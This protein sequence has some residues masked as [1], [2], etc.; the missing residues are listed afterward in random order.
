M[1]LIPRHGVI[2][3]HGNRARLRRARV[4]R[5]DL[6]SAQQ[7][8]DISPLLQIHD[9]LRK[10]DK[11]GV[12]VAESKTVAERVEDLANLEQLTLPSH[13][14]DVVLSHWLVME[15]GVDGAVADVLKGFLPRAHP[16]DVQVGVK[17]VVGLF[18]VQTLHFDEVLMRQPA[19]HGNLKAPV[20]FQHILPA[21]EDGHGLGSREERCQICSVG[22][23]DDEHEP[24][25]RHQH[26]LAAPGPGRLVRR[27]Q[28]QGNAPVHRVH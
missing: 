23:D 21:V 28:Q 26:H 15:G 5:P 4:D 25:V 13:A 17:P 14:D 8:V 2:L 10:G 16:L 7:I 12:V 3:A 27:L 24:A 19:G 9:G 22:G 1:Q 11:V 20:G 6:E 18:E